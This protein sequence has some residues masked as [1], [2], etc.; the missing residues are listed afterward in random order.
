M[1]SHQ[2]SSRYYLKLLS[3]RKR[4]CR[5]GLKAGHLRM[6]RWCLADRS[7]FY[8]VPCSWSSR[9]TFL[10]AASGGW[11][12]GSWG[13][14]CRGRSQSWEESGRSRLTWFC[15]GRSGDGSSPG[16]LPSPS[17]WWCR[18]KPGFQGCCMT[19][20]VLLPEEVTSLLSLEIIHKL[21]FKTLP[22]SLLISFYLHLIKLLVKYSPFDPNYF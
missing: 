22:V 15:T 7:G 17:S 14:S 18:R 21:C 20:H 8:R 5:C 13:G 9:E 3:V 11:S 1:L 16:T 6:L 12:P 2:Q 4:S 19:L 10:P